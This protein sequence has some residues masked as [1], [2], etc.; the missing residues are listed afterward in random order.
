MN[1]T[2]AVRDTAVIGIAAT[3]GLALGVGG[4]TAA[5]WSDEVGFTGE[6]SSGYEYFAAG[7]V[8]ATTP[9]DSAHTAT[10]TI[11]AAEAALLIDDG[12]LAIPMQTDSLSQG[13]KGLRYTVSPPSSWGTGIFGSADVAVFPVTA[14]ADCT[15]DASVPASP[16]HASTPVTADYSTSTTPT[17]EYWCLIATLDG[18][19]DEGGYKNTVTATAKDPSQRDV[20]ANDTW[21][22]NVTSALDPADE[23]DHVI[24]FTYETFRPGE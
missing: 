17:T 7:R 21:S 12:R 10:V 11:G 14:A 8:D 2:H 24:S 23:S 5:Y 19:P 15:V 3:I 16:S 1:R 9:A 4:I 13:N 20:S 18:L 22:A 6:I